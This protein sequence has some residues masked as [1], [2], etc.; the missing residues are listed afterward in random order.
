MDTFYRLIVT[1]Q[2]DQ[3]GLFLRGHVALHYSRLTA[4]VHADAL[5]R[6]FELRRAGSAALHLT[7]PSNMRPISRVTF[8]SASGSFVSNIDT[9]ILGCS[10][11]SYSLAS[12]CLAYRANSIRCDFQ[13]EHRTRYR[14]IARC[15][16]TWQSLL[17][18]TSVNWISGFPRF[19]STV[20]KF[21]LPAQRAYRRRYPC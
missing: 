7:R 16:H 20:Q 1:D 17:R 11:R 5:A 12:R 8:V 2:Y 6:G 14:G 4:A 10:T 19:A 21:S 3:N 13:T 18:S 15:D 9:R